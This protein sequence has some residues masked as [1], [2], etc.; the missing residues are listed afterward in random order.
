MTLLPFFVAGIVLTS[1]LTIG[2][3]YTEPH[4]WL[5]YVCKPLT[6]ILIIVA[7]LLPGTLLANSYGRAIALGLLFSL[8]G[9]IWLNLPQDRFILGLAS[10]LVAHVC[11][12]F[13]FFAGI[14][15]G[16]FA[17]V[18]VLLAL[19]GATVLRYLWPTL[20]EQLKPPVSIYVAVI[21]L[22]A[23]LGVGRMLLAPSESSVLAAVG[24][25]LFMA[26]DAVLAINRFR[27][28]FPLAEATVLGTYFAAQFL[29]A[30]S[31][32]GV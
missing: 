13:A 1:A 32:S 7:A 12:G 8:M 19:V 26:S 9:D 20:S 18:L 28:Q 21:V 29:I 11:Y 14:G 5:M 2:A 31:T 30:L 3:R 24:A 15:A 4:P 6:T 27:R 16:G 17:W 23:S 25:V 22:M 10:F